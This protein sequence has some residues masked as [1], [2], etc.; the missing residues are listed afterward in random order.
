RGRRLLRPLRRQPGG[1]GAVRRL[2]LLLILTLVL[3]LPWPAAA[4]DPGTVQGKV[5]NKS[6]GGDPLPAG[7]TIELFG[8]YEGAPDEPLTATAAADG[9]FTFTGLPADGQSF[10]ALATFMEVT[11]GSAEITLTKDKPSVQVE[12]PVYNT[13]SD[14]AGVGISRNHVIVDFDAE[15]KFLV[16]MDVFTV[17]NKT[18][19]TYIGGEKKNAAGQAETLRLR[20]PD[21]ATHVQLMDGIDESQAGVV[22]G[23]LVDTMPVAPVGRQ[24]II[25]YFL[26]YE[27]PNGTLRRALDYPVENVSLLV[28]DVGAQVEGD[29]LAKQEPRDMGGRRYV[30]LSADNVP[31]GRA[32]EVRFSN[33][34]AQIAPA[35]PSGTTARPA[36][37]PADRLGLAIAG[38]G[39][40][41]LVLG[42]GYPALRR[43]RQSQ[44]AAPVAD[45]VAGWDELVAEIAAL[46]DEFEA[47]RLDEANYRRQRAEKK[48]RLQRLS[49]PG[50]A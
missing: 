19:R 49:R 31:A 22:D 2:W 33:I 43:R 28:R 4:A 38:V 44:A 8:F 24:I 40:L 36:G 20:L 14:G 17:A 29:G 30:Q 21:G 18:D 32:L 42:L 6:A 34:P 25:S 48:G 39:G 26:P 10:V 23:V 15:S 1:E 12:L 11:Y 3:A 27:P 41:L 16:V 9:S 45:G 35:A 7:L 50:R 37:I 46:D 13:T 5:V 47:G